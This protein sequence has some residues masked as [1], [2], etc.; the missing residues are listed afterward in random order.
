MRIGL[1]YMG[2]RAGLCHV[3]YEMAQAMS[4]IADVTCYLSQHNELADEFGQLPLRV[5]D[6]ETYTGYASFLKSLAVRTGPKRVARAIVEDAPDVA[7]D[8]GS[9]PWK[10]II[11]QH[12]RG[13]V[14]AAEIVHDVQHHPDRWKLLWSAV[15]RLLPSSPDIYVGLSRY[16]HEQLVQIHPNAQHV[17]SRLGA[18]H[19][20]LAADPDRI[21]ANRRRMLF[22]GRIEAYKGLDVLVDAFEKAR[23]ANGEIE[24]SVMGAG[25]IAP[26]LAARMSALGVNLRNEWIP[27]GDMPSIIASHGVFVLPY[28]SATQSGIAAIALANGLPSIGTAVGALPEQVMDG[29]NGLIV[30][31]GDA[32][33]LADA[34]VKL[35]GD[36]SLARE[37]SVQTLEIARELY[38]W[39]V[40][41]PQLLADLDK[42]CRSSG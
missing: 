24:L 19:P 38:S 41:A 32:D 26:E 17:E 8:T 11:Q 42:C 18:I 5:R 22:F 21:A 6:F 1:V 15:D 7:L 2:R 23:R 20:S 33:A 9:G 3:T 28:T 12:I 40:I 34:M 30:P 13:R 27:T 31:P 36:E 25:P 35:A 14:P 39:D 4:R 16:S 10:G 37:M 29:R